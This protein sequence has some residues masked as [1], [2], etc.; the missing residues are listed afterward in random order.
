MMRAPDRLHCSDL[1]AVLGTAPTGW[2]SARDVWR[3]IVLEQWVDRDRPELR[4]GR[5]LEPI[6]LGRYV[7]EL[8]PDAA[9]ARIERQVEL[10]GA[11]VGLPMLVGTADAVAR[12]AGES[13]IVE[14]KSTLGWSGWG[15]DGTAEVP[16]HYLAQCAGYLLL[17]PDVARVDLVALEI[18]RWELRRY[19]LDRAALG[20]V[21]TTLREAVVSWWQ[22]HVEPALAE[23]LSYEECWRF[24]PPEPAPQPVVVP[25]GAVFAGPADYELIAR[26][27]DA[28]Q[29]A[30][31]AER[32]LEAAREAL[33]ARLRE[34]GAGALVSQDG[35]R[36]AWLT[37]VEAERVDVRALREAEPEIAERYTVTSQQL[38]L[39]LRRER[40]K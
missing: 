4:R 38:R 15:A 33:I 11:D 14:L 3:R 10:D 7:A 32:E 2:R 19:R 9:R 23:Q 31:E 1:A 24:A 36:L 6:V 29:R 17:A 30:R 40:E 12:Y 13:W 8:E 37:A 21:L 16:P 20:D 39:S 22:R 28:G 26:Y 18:T 35:A 27:R 5:D 34:A 25:A